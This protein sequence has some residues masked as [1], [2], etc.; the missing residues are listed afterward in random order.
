LDGYGTS[1]LI[2]T[3]GR[4]GIHRGGRLHRHTAT[5]GADAGPNPNEEI[6]MS[7][8]YIAPLPFAERRRSN[9]ARFDAI[10]ARLDALS[11]ELRD[12]IT[13]THEIAERL[14]RGFEL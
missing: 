9:D 14:D 13:V 6:I 5:P 8:S 1:V 10:D 7:V 12:L 2:R 3:A 4:P 11:A